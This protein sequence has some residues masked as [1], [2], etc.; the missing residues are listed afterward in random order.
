MNFLVFSRFYC[1]K[2]LEENRWES[3]FCIAAIVMSLLAGLALWVTAQEHAAAVM[4]L[5]SARERSLGNLPTQLPPSTQLPQ[6]QTFP[7]FESAKFTAQ[8]HATALDIGLAFD[9]IAY[10]LEQGN[11]PY[12]RYRLTSSVKAEYHQIRRFIAALA[13]SLPNTELDSVRCIRESAT[14]GRLACDLAFSAFF[15][16]T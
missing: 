6:A 9:E 12:A 14:T 1:T 7:K 11:Q 3:I 10:T 2:W 5:D 8:F 15:A 16:R 4:A 13:V